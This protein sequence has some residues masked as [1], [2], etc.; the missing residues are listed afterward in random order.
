MVLR[1][2]LLPSLP[3]THGVCA[4]WVFRHNQDSVGTRGIY[5]HNNT[6]LS[7]LAGDGTT[8]EDKVHIIKRIVTSFNEIK[9]DF[10][11]AIRWSWLCS[12]FTCKQI[13]QQ[14]C[15]W[16]EHHTSGSHTRDDLVVLRKPLVDYEE[17]L[18]CLTIEQVLCN[19]C[20][21]FFVCGI[22]YWLLYNWNAISWHVGIYSWN[23]VLDAHNTMNQLCFLKSHVSIQTRY[24]TTWYRD[25][26]EEGNVGIWFLYQNVYL[27]YCSYN[28]ILQTKN[29]RWR[30]QIRPLSLT[31]SIM[32]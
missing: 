8:V 6:S 16:R 27:T 5:R 32:R 10:I 7:V 14:S 17:C 24:F 30:Y 20:F 11:L 3:P 28:G 4:I 15:E 18:I 1:C 23:V 13:F 25:G 22:F 9:Y 12:N 31:I 19:E 21:T 2:F 29:V 26:N